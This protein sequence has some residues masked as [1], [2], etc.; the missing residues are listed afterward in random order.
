MK[1][2]KS[3]KK[4][5]FRSEQKNGRALKRWVNNLDVVGNFGRDNIE[6]GYVKLKKA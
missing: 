6:S 3:S 1:E 2:V 5:I 4:I